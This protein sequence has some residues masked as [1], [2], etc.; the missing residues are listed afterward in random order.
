[1]STEILDYRSDP[2]LQPA[3]ALW[4][5]VDSGSAPYRFKA[6]TFEEAL[7]WQAKIRPLLDEIIGFQ[8]IP[9]V[10]PEPELIEQVDR[11]DFIRKKIRMKTTEYTSMPVYLLLPKDK[12]KPFPVILAF[13][14]HGYGVKDIVGLWE[15]GQERLTP[16]GY[17][18]DFAVDLCRKG[19]AVAAPEI[20]CFGERRTDFSQLNTAIGSPIPDTCDHTARLA[21]HL[22]GSVVGLRVLDGKR[23]VDYLETLPELDMSRVGAMGISGGGMH[24]F[25]S[26]C[27][28]TRIKS[29]VISGYFS[30]FRDSILAMHHC[31]C[32]FVPGLAKFGEIYDLA[33]LIAPRPM[34]IEAGAYDPIFPV[35]S[36]DKSIQRTRQ[37]Y[38]VFGA[39]KEIQ[40]DFFEGRHQIN[41]RLAY[42][43]L[44]SYL[45]RG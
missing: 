2:N 4:K 37:V 3:Q 40:A 13:H 35:A 28:D 5:M 12:P 32:N 1:M 19:F 14:G 33:G 18:R 27:L 42:E 23:L 7:A 6:S 22:G 9:R 34:L 16:E 10:N 17:Q 31:A 20:S 29:C 38:Q 43:F 39:E 36:V 15:D 44:A 25:F 24:T 8:G 45:L 21:F 26:T 11:G 41:G 30:A